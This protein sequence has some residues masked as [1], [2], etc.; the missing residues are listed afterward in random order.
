MA[1][2]PY[3]SSL[4]PLGHFDIL[5]TDLAGLKGGEILVFDRLEMGVTDQS[6]ADVFISNDGYRTLLRLAT[7]L[8]TGPFFI[9]AN[10]EEASYNVPGFEL[11]SLYAQNSQY[12][13]MYDASNKVSIYAQEGFY[14]I[15][16]D[17]VD[18]ATVNATTDIYTRLYS[19]ANGNLSATPSASG[20]IVGFFIDYQ[21]GT[22]LRGFPNRFQYAGTH[23][24]GDSVI[25]YKTVGDGYFNLNLVSELVGTLGTL[26]TPSDGYL[27]DG[28]VTSLTST[29][30]IADGVKLINDALLQVNNNFESHLTND[31]HLQY[32]RTDGTR[33]ITGEITLKTHA[34]FTGSEVRQRTFAI[35]TTGDTATQLATLTLADDTVYWFE[36]N[37]IGRDVAGTQRGFYIRNVRAHRQSGGV[38]TLGTINEQFTD[39][40]LGSMDATF[41]VS[42]NDLQVTVTGVA[43]TTINWACTLKYQG[44]S[45][46]V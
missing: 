7:S 25:F 38:A 45:G 36:S 46:S 3:Q 18:T 43:A 14:S 27:S 34:D 24:S 33:T 4:T 32:A 35:Q 19:D 2:K 13:Q 23:R 40:T 37:I 9:S 41:T 5:D 30:T 44:V 21:P 31:D 42:G 16:S 20:S 17:V 28:Y 10:Q 12:G 22:Q 6:T 26:G 39:E 15:S 11:T 1:I 8:D 29:T